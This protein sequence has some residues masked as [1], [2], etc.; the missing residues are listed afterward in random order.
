MHRCPRMKEGMNSFHFS[1]A[2]ICSGVLLELFSH[3][4]PKSLVESNNAK[5]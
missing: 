5:I 1:A 2:V 3:G 4:L